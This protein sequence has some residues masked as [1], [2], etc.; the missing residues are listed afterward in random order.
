M[1]IKQF[2]S[3]KPEEQTSEICLKTVKQY[4]GVIM[5]VKDQTDE[6]CLE[7]VKQDWGAIEYVKEPYKRWLSEFREL[8]F[9]QYSDKYPEYLL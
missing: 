2:K 8:S 6:I 7:A 5:Y 4:W 3:L 9:E 1:T